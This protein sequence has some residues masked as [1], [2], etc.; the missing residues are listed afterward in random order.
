MC[1]GKHAE[2]LQGSERGGTH[3]G[4]SVLQ[5]SGGGGDVARVS[6]D[7]DRTAIDGRHCL[8]RSVRVITTYAVPKAIVIATTAP[9]T[10]AMPELATTAHKRR[11][12]LGLL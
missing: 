12:G 5:T 7:G 2:S 3:R 4:I 8:R 1:I 9:I 11:R 10:S 6:G